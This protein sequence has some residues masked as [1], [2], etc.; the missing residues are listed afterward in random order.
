MTKNKN[1]NLRGTEVSIIKKGELE[2]I[3]LT[4]MA[5]S[6]IQEVVIIK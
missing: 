4:D 6:Q 5:R 3:S 1:I 2:Y